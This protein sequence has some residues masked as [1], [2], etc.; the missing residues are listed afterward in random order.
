M[1]WLKGLRPNQTTY[2]GGD[3]GPALTLP[4]DGS[5]VTAA[6]RRFLYALLGG[7]ACTVF[8]S[9]LII[10]SAFGSPVPLLDQWDGEGALLYS[11]YLKG[12]LSFASLLASHNGHRILVTRLLALGH[13]ELTGEW[14]TRLEMI[15]GA[16]VL[17]AAVTW[18]AALLMPLVARDRQLL[19]SC[20]VAIVFAFPIDYEN[21]VWGFQSQ[22]YLSLLFGLA[23]LV[24]FASAAPFSP[25]WFAGL[26]AGV[27]AYFTFAT[28]VAALLAAGSLVSLQLVTNVR[29]RCAREVIAVLTIA[30]IAV[31]LTLWGAESTTTMS[32][33]W[34]FLGG[35]GIFAA[36]TFA[37]IVPIVLYCRRTLARRPRIGDRAWV[38]LG[39]SAWLA[40]QLALF[41]VGRGIHVAP[42]Y[43]DVV[44]LAYLVA[45][46]AV[47]DL[48][49]QAPSE[50]VGGKVRLRARTWVIP[51]IVVMTV[52]GCA[53]VLACNFWSR[54]A[55]QQLTDVRA[56]LAT[57][58]VEHLTELGGPT[59]GIVLRHPYPERQARALDDPALRAVLPREIRPSDADNSRARDRMVLKG[60][61]A[62]ITATA[63]QLSFLLAPG[64]LALGLAILIAVGRAQRRRPEDIRQRLRRDR[65]SSFPYRRR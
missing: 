12:T 36:L 26:G 51:V 9:R 38:M 42:R 21:T 4:P 39:V 20:F 25:C 64:V 52:V 59:H 37:A 23:A 49:D 44:L 48:S 53:S 3:E 54:A 5:R 60:K 55:G 15:V 62:P 30:L 40:I 10:I 13:L 47:L 8:G 11:P 28:G 33:L 31:G 18:L 17:T 41:A 29:K 45:L 2:C 14:N 58:D 16:L 19:L 35:L 7:I 63:V 57:G 6:P 24:A 1:I 32:N 34:T 22:V 27:L 65:V 50:V 56:Y 61:L 43:M 46:V